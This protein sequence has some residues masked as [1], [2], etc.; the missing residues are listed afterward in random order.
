[1]LKMRKG[2]T[3]PFPEMLRDFGIYFAERRKD[4]LGIKPTKAEE[5]ERNQG[6]KKERLPHFLDPEVGRRQAVDQL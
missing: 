4:Y 2:C 1:M 5:A 3:V 6:D